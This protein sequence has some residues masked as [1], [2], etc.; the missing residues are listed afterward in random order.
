MRGERQK[1]LLALLGHARPQAALGAA[2]AQAGER[3]EMM[4]S[5]LIVPGPIQLHR[6]VCRDACAGRLLET[7]AEPGARSPCASAICQDQ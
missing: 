5:K 7:D 6:V 3:W 2:A 4:V 1:R